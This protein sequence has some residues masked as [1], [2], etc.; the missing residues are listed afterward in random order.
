[1]T[2]PRAPYFRKG[3]QALL[4]GPTQMHGHLLRAILRPGKLQVIYFWLEPETYHQ[5]CSGTTYVRRTL[6]AA[7]VQSVQPNVFQGSDARISL[8][9]TAAVNHLQTVAQ[10]AGYW[11]TCI[12]S[13]TGIR[14]PLESSP[15]F[16]SVWKV[17]YAPYAARVSPPLP[18]QTFSA[19]LYMFEDLIHEAFA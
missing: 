3:I 11:V 13:L 17:D 18:V 14:S 12:H 16:V 15:H 1:M 9:S 8:F 7:L 10:A 2:A 6:N 19:G 5:L 4:A